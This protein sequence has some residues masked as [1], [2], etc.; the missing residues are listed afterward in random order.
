MK[1]ISPGRK[2]VQERDIVGGCVSIR[3]ASQ[4]RV[5]HRTGEH[6]SSQRGPRNGSN[7]EHLVPIALQWLLRLGS[8]AQTY[9]KSREH[10]AFLLAIEQAV[11]VLHG[12]EWREV[13]CD[14]IV[15]NVLPSA[16]AVT[17]SVLYVL[18]MA[19]TSIQDDI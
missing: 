9:L 3:L 15:C 11:M 8:R 13:V 6:T 10:L 16:H 5:P 12:D 2:R 19:W 7:A 1:P 17:S 14:R 4:G 18:C